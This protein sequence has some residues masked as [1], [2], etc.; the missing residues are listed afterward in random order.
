M[1]NIILSLC[2]LFSS[3]LY[4]SCYKELCIDDVVR[5]IYGWK[6]SVVSFDAEK[7]NVAVL[8]HH[9]G[10]TFNFPY[11]ELGK[12][13]WCYEVFCQGDEL[14]DQ[15]GNQIIIEEVYTHQML[16]AFNLNIDGFALYHFDELRDN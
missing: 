13:V 12:L 5:D 10:F 9:N 4:A 15:Y 2:F 8:L 16:Y 14:K 1:K 11:D 7:E 3:Q 6:G